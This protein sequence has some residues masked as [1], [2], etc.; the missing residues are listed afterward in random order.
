VIN[1]LTV[2][3]EDWFHTNAL[4]ISPDKWEFYPSTVTENTL[5]ILDLFDEH[6]TKATFFVLGW[7][8][9]KHP[10]LV[11]EIVKR[12]HE[13]GSHGVNHQLVSQLS[14]KEF[15]TDLIES[16]SLL[17]DASG[18]VVRYYRAPSWSISKEKLEVLLIMEEYGIICDSSL[19]PFKTP[20]SGISGLPK[21][22]YI[23][24][25][26]NRVL[27]L[28]E[29]PPTVCD[30]GKFPYAGG[31]YLRLFPYWF[32]RYCLKKLN[33]RRAGLVYIHPWE[34]DQN[35]PKILASPHIRFIHHYGIKGTVPKLNDLLQD[36]QFAS[37]GDVIKG[38]DYPQISIGN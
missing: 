21:D 20:L 16:L 19:Q 7:V 14:I 30:L 26:G 10:K 29:F 35:G 3:V 8:A 24:V 11:Q 18:K 32:I 9:K 17:E 36:F 37:I 22:P 2:D 6:N 12:G 25:L 38:Q 27:N 23:P 33:E 5:K 15:K 28:I 1:A 13:I 34:L 4:S 31:F